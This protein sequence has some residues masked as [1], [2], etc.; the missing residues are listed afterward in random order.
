MPNY[1]KITCFTHNTCII[2]K[3]MEVETLK[4]LIIEYDIALQK[5][6]LALREAVRNE[7]CG[8][9]GKY[10]TR[11]EITSQD[12]YKTNKAIREMAKNMGIELQQI[13]IP[14]NPERIL[15]PGFGEE[16]EDYYE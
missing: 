9:G 1:K 8:F 12:S 10:L 4:K 5:T 16:E 3:H 2:N 13:V 15:R 6:I 14:E 7:N 11:Q